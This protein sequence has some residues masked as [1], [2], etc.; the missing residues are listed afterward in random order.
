MFKKYNYIVIAALLIVF[1]ANAQIRPTG[2]GNSRQIGSRNSNSENSENPSDTESTDK[3]EKK[4]IP[5][6]IKVWQ[7]DDQGSLIR[8]AELDTTLWFYHNYLP[9]NQ[10]SISNTFTGN[11]GGAYISNDFFKRTSNSDF[12]FARSFDAYWLNPS[13]IR[14]YNTTTPYSLLDYSQSENRM[15]HNETRFN[16][17]HSQNINKNLNFEFIYNQTRSSGQ[18]QNQENKF[19]SIGL[20][21]SYRSDRFLSHSNIIFN[22][23]Q[24]QENGGIDEGQSFDG[25]DTDYLTVKISDD[26]INKLQNNNVLTINEYRVGKTIESEADTSG[27]VT[28]TFIPRVG[29]IHEFEFSDNKRKFTK[30]NSTDFFDHVNINGT[31][32]NDSVKYSRLTNIF[33]IKFY[34]APDRKFTFGKRAFIGYDNLWY[35][36]ST[37]WHHLAIRYMNTPTQFSNTFIGGGIFRDE[38]KF[39]Q[40]EA[41]GKIYFAG[42]R[43]GQTELSGFINK[44]MKIG[45]DTTSLRIEGSLKTLV[46]EYFDQY[47]YSNHFEWRNNFNNIN[48]MTIRSSIHSQAY[49]T[50]IGANYSLIG[51]YIYNN[52]RALP[53]QASSELLI[54]SAYLNKDF[55]SR[56]WLI[57]TQLLVQKGNKDRYLHLPAFAGFMSINYRTVWSK[58]LFTQLGIDTRYNSAFYADAYEPAT[59]R[60][61]LQNRQRIGNFPYIDLHANLKL[62]R[63]RFFF[64]LMNAASGFA[65]D[66]YFVAPDYPNYRRT[67]RLGVAWSFY[68]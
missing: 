19:H 53:A 33:Q 8:P 40:W 57:R 43:S 35:H 38:G 63:T 58:V 46:P 30:E 14:Y 13:Q 28:K 1:Q 23:L 7:V 52:T 31:T 34:E 36:S 51:N 10:V 66:N 44:P 60:F 59:A 62:K 65:G 25:I 27:F 11:N 21:T 45:R 3:K 32:T 26:A 24:G 61:Y 29:F 2:S 67:F 6:V 20:V 18:Y 12:Y 48:E 55:D 64:I 17:F 54:L 47:F 9:F 15:T 37:Q 50:T 39:W 4:K 56:H 49:K 5:S 41:E 22:R 68:D 42:Y 16:V